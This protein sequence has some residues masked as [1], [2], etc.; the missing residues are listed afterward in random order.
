MIV[1]FL[2]CRGSRIPYDILR[3][4]Q[5]HNPAKPPLNI[6]FQRKNSNHCEIGK[7]CGRKTFVPHLRS[8]FATFLYFIFE[9]PLKYLTARTHP[10]SDYRLTPVLGSMI[11]NF[12]ASIQPENAVSFRVS[13]FNKNT[14]KP[15]VNIR[16]HAKKNGKGVLL[17]PL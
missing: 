6:L 2:V 4:Q 1:E 8:S 15:N 11:L 7:Q 5:G 10:L 12:S 16:S 9:R 17:R 13:L 14:S 3:C